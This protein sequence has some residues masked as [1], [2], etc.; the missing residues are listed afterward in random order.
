L[1]F[2]ISTNTT[3]MAAGRYLE[4]AQR[5]IDKS[6]QSLAS[7][8]RIVHAGDDAAG[9]AIAESL[10][11]QLGGAK[12]AKFNAESAVGLVQTAEGGLSEL[13]NILVRLRELA[14]YSASDTIG[15]DERGFLD[16]EYQGL[17]QEFDRIAKSTRYGNKSL[18]TGSGEEFQFQVG[19]FKGPENVITFS[20][21]ANTTASDVGIEGTGIHSKS[22]ALSSL[23]DID[24]AMLKVAGARSTFG[25][26][27]SRLEHT[28]AALG[29]QAENLDAA[30]GHIVDVDAAEESSKLAQAQLLQE[31]GTAVVAQANQ[32]AQRALHLLVPG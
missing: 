9:F 28:I 26:M 13:N 30:R 2:K 23:N 27:Q 18:L 21:D 24:G 29:V 4:A 12:Q 20:L 32:T 3:A 7:G 14:V 22:D 6:L 16:T 11:G 17:S 15:D 5:Q 19:A 10:R 25:G 1:A 31:A 8:S